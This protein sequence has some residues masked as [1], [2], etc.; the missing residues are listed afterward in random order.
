MTNHYDIVVIGAG[1]SGMAA[2]CVAAENGARTL[3]L[4]EQG[5]PGGQI[6]RA[7]EKSHPG[8]GPDFGPSYAKGRSLSERFRQSGAE[9]VS[10]AA[11]W[12]VSANREIGYS[13]DGISRLLTADQ[14]IIAT[15]A[16]E[17]PIPVPGWTLPGVMTVGAAQILLKDAGVAMENAIFAGTGPLLYAA[18]YQYLKAGIPIKAVLDLTPRRN[19]LR[20]L[21]HLPKALP[22]L[23]KIAEGWLWKQKIALSKAPYLQWVSQIKISGE[24]NATGVTYLRHGHWK[25]IDA[26]HVLLHLGVEMGSGRKRRLKPVKDRE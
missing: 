19:Y 23:P 10:G 7:I 13:H 4:D 1:P 26:E 5:T 3:V 18:V 16:Q 21:A 14:V 2:A 8:S 22:S 25:Q 9:Y 17:R 15:G 24:D 11:V 12:L 20:A 6:Y